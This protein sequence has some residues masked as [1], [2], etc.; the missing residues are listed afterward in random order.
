MS[1]EWGDF[2]N[3]LFQKGETPLHLACNINKGQLHFPNE[4]IQIMEILLKHGGTNCCLKMTRSTKE[5]PLHYVAT[6]GNADILATLLEALD[7]GQIQGGFLIFNH[8]N[9]LV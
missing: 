2:F 9:R 3:V 6:T 1:R 8:L 7:P 5:T 4:D